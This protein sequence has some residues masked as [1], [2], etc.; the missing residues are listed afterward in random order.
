G[1]YQIAGTL[2][3]ANAA[4][5]TNA[6]NLALIGAGAITD[7]FGNNALAGLTSV[8]AGNSL[9]LQNGAIFTTTSTL[10]NAG[11]LRIDATSALAVGG[12]FIQTAS[13]TTLNGMLTAMTVV[14]GPEKGSEQ[15]RFGSRFNLWF[16]PNQPSG[17]DP[18]SPGSTFQ[19]RKRTKT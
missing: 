18:G 17:A 10:P 1:T 8:T 5:A 2:Q 16:P 7:L 14:D 3:F 4:I 6:A 15:K 9:S 13:N 11:E 19:A 12:S